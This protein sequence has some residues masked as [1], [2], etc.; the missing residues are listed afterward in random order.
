MAE[1]EASPRTGNF[2][3]SELSSKGIKTA[4][5]KLKI[6][7]LI[8]LILFSSIISNYCNLYELFRLL[9]VY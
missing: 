2:S 4:K 9:G 1:E 7:I 5:K 6:D 8:R 3:S